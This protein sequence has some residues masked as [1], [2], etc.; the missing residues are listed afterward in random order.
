MQTVKKILLKCKDSGGDRNIAQ[1][2]LRSTPLS[3][4]LR[5]PA[6]HLN[7]RTFITTLPVKISV[8]H[9][10]EGKRQL[11]S[12]QQEKQVDWYDRNSKPMPILFQNQPVQ[13]QDTVK[14]TWTPSKI[15]KDGQTPR[16]YVVEKESGVQL[17]RRNR[18]HVKPDVQ[19]NIN[20]ISPVRKENQNLMKTTTTQAD[21]IEIR[22]RSGRL[23]KIPNSFTL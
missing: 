16:S 21:G 8:P 10:Q 5:S 17:I 12:T 9:D 18:N 11:L 20:L 13:I 14:K 2:T 15:V 7:R 6:E 4:K 3:A 19:A 22:T 1:L 23:S